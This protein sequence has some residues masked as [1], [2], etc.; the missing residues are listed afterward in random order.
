MHTNPFTP[1]GYD[2]SE[3]RSKIEQKADKHEIHS[4][5]S[6]VDRLERTNEE[7][8]SEIAELRARCERMAEVLR[9]INPGLASVDGY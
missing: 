3:L 7:R 6:D 1:A 5:R 9:E 2:L 8:R 4:L